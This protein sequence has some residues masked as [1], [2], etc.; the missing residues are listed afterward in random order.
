MS[1]WKESTSKEIWMRREEMNKPLE[2]I[3]GNDANSYFF[4]HYWLKALWWAKAVGW[5]WAGS[6]S[7]HRPLAERPWARQLLQVIVFCCLSTK[8]CFHMKAVAFHR[9]ETSLCCSFGLSSTTRD[10]YPKGEL[11]NI[12]TI[13]LFKSLLR[14]HEATS[15][16]KKILGTFCLNFK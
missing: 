5:S 7:D 6:S 15:I 3:V 10:I 2:G 13:L 1:W 9:Q 12:F 14:T 4:L 8:N 16:W 11:Q